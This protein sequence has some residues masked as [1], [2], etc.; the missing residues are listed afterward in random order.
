MR[1]LS[2]AILSTVFYFKLCR[3]FA[4]FSC[5]N[6]EMFETLFNL[7]QRINHGK[8]LQG[9]QGV[10][11]LSKLAKRKVPRV[12]NHK[13]FLPYLAVATSTMFFSLINSISNSNSNF[14][15]QLQ[16]ELINIA[17]Q[18]ATHLYSHQVVILTLEVDITRVLHV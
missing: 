9:R 2:T 3:R 5:S 8:L 1:H 11:S 10:T 6:E 14:R 13:A 17:G 18:K 16:L 4:Q 12:R 7:S 15:L